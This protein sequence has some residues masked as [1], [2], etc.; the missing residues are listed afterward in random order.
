MWLS[1]RPR[2]A[3]SCWRSAIV[4]F[5]FTTT[6][7]CV[8]VLVPHDN[9]E[10]RFRGFAL[11]VATGGDN[12]LAV[13]NTHILVMWVAGTSVAGLPQPTGANKCKERFPVRCLACRHRRSRTHARTSRIAIRRGH[14]PRVSLIASAVHMA[15]NGERDTCA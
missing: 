2:H 13:A 9:P 6:Q 15:T 10:R 4:D 3:Y 1:E 12:E 7:D 8:N 14:Q 5:P 11:R